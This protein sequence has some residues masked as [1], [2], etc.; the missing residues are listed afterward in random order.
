MNR[1]LLTAGIAC[2]KENRII[3]VCWVTAGRGCQLGAG[4]SYGPSFARRDL[5]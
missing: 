1:K 2:P 3:L 5:A 4:F